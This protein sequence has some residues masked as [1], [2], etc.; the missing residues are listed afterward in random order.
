MPVALDLDWRHASGLPTRHPRKHLWRG[1]R[2][3]DAL[4]DTDVVSDASRGNRAIVRIVRFF[5]GPPPQNQ[6]PAADYSRAPSS[7]QRKVDPAA[8]TTTLVVVGDSMADWL[9]YG[10]EEAFAETPEMAI[11]RKHRT[12]SGL[13]RYDTRRDV[14]WPQ[15]VKEVIAADKPKRNV[16]MMGL[17]A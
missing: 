7:P 11:V 8:A 2:F 13:I 12:I 6:A 1:A 3:R 16:M 15:I 5:G 4:R 17:N 14:E 9:A 10:L